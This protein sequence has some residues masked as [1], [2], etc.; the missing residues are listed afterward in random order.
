MADEY[1]ARVGASSDGANP[2]QGEA[3][4]WSERNG[5]QNR[6]IV[7]VKHSGLHVQPSF[8]S[9]PQKFANGNSSSR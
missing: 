1:F 9:L 4:H 6:A 7:Q 3:R 2:D 8:S 5:L